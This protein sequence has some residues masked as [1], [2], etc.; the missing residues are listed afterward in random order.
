M[1]VSHEKAGL[2]MQIRVGAT[3]GRTLRCRFAV[4]PPP[5]ASLIAC[6]GL[7]LL[8]MP[9]SDRVTF[10]NRARKLDLKNRQELAAGRGMA[11]RVDQNPKFAF[12][13][14][15]MIKLIPVLCPK[16]SP[17]ALLHHDQPRFPHLG[18]WSC[19]DSQLLIL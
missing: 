11:C 16:I 2:E 9:R 19:S 1:G 7:S 15:S 14:F 4:P 8:K 6:G 12:P 10:Q 3:P 18:A 13:S 5:Q 17:L